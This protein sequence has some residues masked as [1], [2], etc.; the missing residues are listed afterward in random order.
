MEGDGDLEGITGLDS[1]SETMSTRCLLDPPDLSLHFF[2]E[3]FLNFCC[4]A[5]IILSLVTFVFFPSLD[6]DFPHHDGMSRKKLVKHREDK[7]KV[8]E[9]SANYGG[10]VT[11]GT[12]AKSM[13]QMFVK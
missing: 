5:S 10:E 7:R 9:I 11:F 12:R 4:I 13:T 1:F 6:E 3:A 8:Q 2:S